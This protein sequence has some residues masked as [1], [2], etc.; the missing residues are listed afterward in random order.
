MKLVVGSPAES[1]DPA[2][3]CIPV[4]SLHGM[5][6]VTSKSGHPQYHTG[7]KPFAMRRLVKTGK[8][9]ICTSLRVLSKIPSVWGLH[10]S[11][12]PEASYPCASLKHSRSTATLR[13]TSWPLHVWQRQLSDQQPAMLLLFYKIVETHRHEE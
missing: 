13:P 7:L 4:H 3:Q 5:Q 9:S 8:T 11:A 2:Y 12:L 6:G 1:A 10:L